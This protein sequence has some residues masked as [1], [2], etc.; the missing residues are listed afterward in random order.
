MLAI[1]QA[2]G[3]IKYGHSEVGNFTVGDLEYEQNEIEFAPRSIEDAADQLLIA[4]WILRTLALKHG[5]TVTFAPKITAG[6]AGS[7][8]H[9]HCRLM[10]DGKSQMVKDGV[11][12]DVARK[13]IA[14][15]LDLAPSITAFGN[16][17]PMSYF[18]L[19][20]HQEAPTNIC[21]GDRNRSVLVR[22]PLGWTGKL[23]MALNA[24][25][26]QKIFDTRPLQRQTVELRSP[27]GSA[28]VYTLMA[29]LAVAAR[30]GLEM[31]NALSLAEATYV[32]VD[33]FHAKNKKKLNQLN[34]LPVSCWESAEALNKQKDIYL[35]YGIFSKG[36]IDGIIAYHKSYKDQNLRRE[37][38]DKPGELMNLVS[39]F[40]HCG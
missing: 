32:D 29:S 14:G 10:K 21:W 9:I 30:Y 36:M 20:P 27:D 28:D 37:L 33:I 11:L 23:D 40:F 6:K 12:T 25:P 19:V 35:E 38:K 34:H 13:T 18:R 3:L 2:G 1:A 8:L 26:V 15:F 39:R 22:V 16:L 7:G 31:K 24:N 4:K 5:V 17:N